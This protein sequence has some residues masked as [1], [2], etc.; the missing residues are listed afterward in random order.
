MDTAKTLNGTTRRSFLGTLALGVLFA[1]GGC[2]TTSDFIFNSDAPRYTEQPSQVVVQWEP[3]VRFVPDPLRNGNLNP[4]LACRVYLFGPE[5]AVPLVGD[6]SLR[7]EMFDDTQP[8][9]KVLVEY[10]TFDP[11][12][13]KRSLRR[14]PCGWGYTLFLPSA[15]LTPQMNKVQLNVRYEQATGPLFTNSGPMLLNTTP[16]NG[17]GVVRTSSNTRT[18]APAPRPAN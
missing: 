3:N 7:I 18:P 1:L 14:D 5:P 16:Q 11:D 13:L 6:G 4:G 8:D 17:V 10:W 2:D 12:T 9:G 15:R